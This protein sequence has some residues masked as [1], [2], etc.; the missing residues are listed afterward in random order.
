M[1]IFLARLTNHAF[2]A[3]LEQ[4]KKGNNPMFYQVIE[5]MTLASFLSVGLS[6]AILVLLL[7]HVYFT[8][9]N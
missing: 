1:G 3:E 7:T 9:N 8:F 2:E 4:F 5:R 6:V